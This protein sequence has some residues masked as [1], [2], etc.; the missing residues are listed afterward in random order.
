MLQHPEHPWFLRHCNLWLLLLRLLLWYIKSRVSAMKVLRYL[1]SLLEP[2]T[3][4]QNSFELLRELFKPEAKQMEGG[5]RECC[6]VRLCVCC[7]HRCEYLVIPSHHHLYVRFFQRGWV[8]NYFHCCSYCFS[9]N[10]R[11]P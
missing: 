2:E 4:Y 11:D 3:L 10:P 1:S 9:K 5:V 8:C 6:C 7:H